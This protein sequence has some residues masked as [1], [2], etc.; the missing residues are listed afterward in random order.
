M[1]PEDEG[2]ECCFTAAVGALEVPSIAGEDAPGYVVEDL[3][4]H[5]Y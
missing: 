1:V 4:R 3:R 5:Q 2:E